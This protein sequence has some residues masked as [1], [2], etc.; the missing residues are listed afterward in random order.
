MGL[1]TLSACQVCD[2]LRVGP[3]VVTGCLGE[4][5]DWLR[6][7]RLTSEARMLNMVDA[8][9]Q[10][11]RSTDVLLELVRKSEPFNAKRYLESA[12]S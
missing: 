1:Y 2:A 12:Y 3:Q 7:A 9:I 5:A 6:R 11:S 8:I 10:F 4:D